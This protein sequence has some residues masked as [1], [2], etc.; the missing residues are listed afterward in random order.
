[1]KL[2]NSWLQNYGP[3]TMRTDTMKLYFWK[4]YAK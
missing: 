4:M 2:H 3:M 1:M